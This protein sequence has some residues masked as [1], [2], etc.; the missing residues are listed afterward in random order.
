PTENGAMEAINGWL[1]EE[2]FIDFHINSCNDIYQEI[3][4]YI[5]YFN[6]NRP[7]SALNYLTP[8][9]YKNL[10]FQK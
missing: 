5:L 4:K 10:H 2:L 3:D 6:N 7:Q 8:A 1:K 9:Q